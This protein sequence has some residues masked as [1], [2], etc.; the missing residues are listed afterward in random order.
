LEVPTAISDSL[1]TG[2]IILTRTADSKANTY[3][4]FRILPRITSLVPSSGVETDPVQINGNHFCETG[5]C[6]TAGN[7]NTAADNITFYNGVSVPD[8]DVSTWTHTQANVLVP[9]GAATGNVILRSNNYNSNGAAFTVLSATPGDPTS[10]GQYKIDA[11]TAISTGGGTNETTVKLKMTMDASVNDTLYPQ[12][13][14]KIV[15][16]AFDETGVLEGTGV[17]YT[18]T[19][20]IGWVFAPGLVNG[21]SYHWRARIRRGTYYSNWV[22]FGGNVEN[23]PT[24]PA[25]IDF[26]I[27]TAAP[28]I[29][30]GSDGTCTTASSSITDLSATIVWITDE[31]STSQVEYG[32]DSNLAGS[33]LFPSSPSDSVTAHTVNLSGLT[34]AT[35]YYFRVRSKDALNNEGISPAVSP[36]CSFT[37]TAAVLRPMKTIEY[38]INQNTSQLTSPYASPT[39]TWPFIAYISET[40]PVIKSAFIEV[41]GVSSGDV[42]HDITIQVNTAASLVASLDSSLSTEAFTVLYSI[43]SPDTDLVI[44]TPSSPTV[45]NDLKITLGGASTTSLLSAKLILTYYYTP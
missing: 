19:P 17:S 34:A 2:D 43:P 35:T 38:Y 1:Y 9:I 18:G 33:T 20:V 32:T 8:A 7:R 30:L 3:N 44:A 10:L 41:S 45:S 36:Y 42:D 13:E 24:N 14:V 12:V 25:D 23:P 26:Y 40:S 39:V 28:V 22:S 16:T 37:T 5:T 4:N 21:N 27:D 6:P 11:I 15:T 31:N 29:T